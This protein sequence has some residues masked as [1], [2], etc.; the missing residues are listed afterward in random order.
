MWD[1]LWAEVHAALPEGGWDGV[2]GCGMGLPACQSTP[3]LPPL[4]P[5]PLPLLSL[6]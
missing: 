4:L 5:L 6:L 2:G 1:R 3:L